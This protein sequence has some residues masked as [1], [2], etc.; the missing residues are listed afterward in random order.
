LSPQLKKDE[1]GNVI[2]ITSPNIGKIPLAQKYGFKDGDVIQ[3][4]NGVTIDSEQRVMEV[5]SRYQ[6][7][8]T[9]YV[10]ILRDGKPQTLVFRVE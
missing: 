8:P 10:S 6:N 2:G 3:T 1:N 4:I 5:L 7:A 9:H